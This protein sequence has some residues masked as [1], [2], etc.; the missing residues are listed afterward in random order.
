MG[1]IGGMILC[2]TFVGEWAGWDMSG[3]VCMWGRTI[4]ARLMA[5]TQRLHVVA[6]R[7]YITQ[8]VSPHHTLVSD[9]C[10]AQAF[11]SSIRQISMLMLTHRHMGLAVSPT[12]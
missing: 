3:R 7:L 11:E 12:S 1:G 4:L 6:G 5:G 8:V 2:G 10:V 9:M